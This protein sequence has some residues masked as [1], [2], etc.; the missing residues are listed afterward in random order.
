MPS[1]GLHGSFCGQIYVT[2][3][4]K[5]IRSSKEV[6]RE[7]REWINQAH[8]TD[9]CRFSMTAVEKRS[10]VMKFGQFLN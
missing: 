5:N 10:A 6:P 3:D 1:L 4:R 2:L 7:E 8:G 9:K